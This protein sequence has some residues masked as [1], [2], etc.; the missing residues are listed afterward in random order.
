MRLISVPLF[1]VFL[2][3]PLA[4]T[5]LAQDLPA[6]ITVSAEG[7]VAVSP[8][9]ATI[10]LGV[11][12]QGDT[13]AEAMRSNS[14]AL[15]AVLDRLRGAGI[16]DRDLQTSNLSLNPNWQGQND[17]AAP[18]IMGYIASNMLT[19]RVRD[20][21]KVGEV[22]DAVVSDGANTL[23]GISFDLADPDPAMDKARTN[24]VLTA[25]ARAEL[26]ATAAGVKL[27]Q[28]LSISEGGGMSSPQPMYRMQADMVGSA[29][30]VAGGEVGI[31]A[32][33]TMVFAITQN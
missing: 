20:L 2:A 26:L 5:V 1:A 22:L 29:V 27:G 21:D 33:V 19:V 16:E 28:I 30:P 10:T 4:Q 17:G 23:N 18:Q 13:A 11:T 24:A 6:T 31:S 12:T 14:T 15:G 8:D 9:L 32:S 25:R 7:H 3:L